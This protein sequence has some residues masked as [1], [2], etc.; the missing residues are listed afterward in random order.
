MKLFVSLA[1]ITLILICFAA[2]VSCS[3]SPSGD[4]NKKAQQLEGKSSS[5]GQPTIFDAAYRGDL[6]A[7]RHLVETD[8][9]DIHRTDSVGQTALTVACYEG[10][11]PVVE[12]LVAKGLGVDESG[13]YGNTALMVA[14][15]RGD[16][17]L[18]QY[19]VGNEAKVNQQ[20]VDGWTALMKAA[21]NSHAEV[22]RYLMEHG[23]N[24]GLKDKKG[25]TALDYAQSP[26]VKT[27]L[28]LS[29]VAKGPQEE[30]QKNKSAKD[31][32]PNNP[33]RR[34]ESASREL[35][36]GNQS[37]PYRDGGQRRHR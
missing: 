22:I 9:V 37:P 3:D 32:A 11:L 23:A 27:L 15:S 5:T 6:G 8:R 20:D 26:E 18:V 1:D 10:H 34:T 19:L 12:Y 16:L 36:E 4:P 30:G 13:Y 33:P 31:D 2:V 17:T 21:L 7:V 14:A 25:N 35:A 24:P 29:T 28:L